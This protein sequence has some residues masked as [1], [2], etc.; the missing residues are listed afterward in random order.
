MTRLVGYIKSQSP[1]PEKN[2]DYQNGTKKIAE[3]DRDLPKLLEEIRR[4]PW[5]RLQTLIDEIRNRN[6]LFIHWD[7]AAP[8]QHV[9]P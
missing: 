3:I 1:E 8:F 5:D 2:I 4:E 9:H 6:A 7:P